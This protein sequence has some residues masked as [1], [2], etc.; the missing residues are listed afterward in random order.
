MTDSTAGLES[1]VQLA[2]KF[3]P[4]LFSLLFLFVITKISH[5]YYQKVVT[6]LHPPPTTREISDYRLYFLSSVVFSILFS[7]ASGTWWWINSK[8]SKHVLQVTV[9]NAPSNVLITS[10]DADAYSKYESVQGPAAINNRTYSFAF[11]R[12][13]PFNR[14][15]KIVFRYWISDGATGGLGSPN[16]Q[17]YGITYDGDAFPVYDVQFDPSSMLKLVKNQ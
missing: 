2:Y 14:G 3:G 15:D 12:D 16:V 8:N 13:A 1:L 5:T 9:Q 11:I 10:N 4:F 6:R 17:K 7:I